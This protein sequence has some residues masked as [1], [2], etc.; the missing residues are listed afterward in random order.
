[1]EATRTLFE[2][3]PP[4]KCPGEG[5]LVIRAIRPSDAEGLNALQ[6]LPGFRFGTLRL[7]YQTLEESRKFIESRAAGHLGIVALVDDRIVGSAS[8]ER[9]TGR[10]SHAGALGMGVHDDCVGRGIGKALLRALLDTADNWMN[11]TRLEL[12]VFVDN[13]PAIALYERHGFEKEG[14]LRAYAFRNGAFVDAYA[15]ARIRS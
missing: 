13:A 6:N 9:L 3:Q 1:M 14:T 5:E 2:R 8:L 7:P 10:R 11:L 12:T 4:P 15:M